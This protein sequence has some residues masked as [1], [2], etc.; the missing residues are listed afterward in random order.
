MGKVITFLKHVVLSDSFGA[1]VDASSLIINVLLFLIALLTFI[2]TFLYNGV[3]L[4][5]LTSHHSMFYGNHFG[6]TIKNKSFH[7]ISISEVFIII[8][9]NNNYYRIK[10]YS[11]KTPIIIEPLSISYIQSDDFT[12]IN[13]ID[14]Y[15]N[16]WSKD[17]ILGIV[18]GEKVLWAKTSKNGLSKRVAKQV[19]DGILTQ[20]VKEKFGTIISVAVNEI[21]NEKVN[22]TLSD[23]VASNET[24]QEDN[25]AVEAEESINEEGIITTDSEK[26][27]YF[28]VRSIASEILDVNRVAMRDRKH[29]CN[30][31]FDDNQ[32]FPIVRLHFNNPDHLRVEFYDEITLTSNGGKKGEKVD[33]EDVS[34]LYTHKE[35]VLNV[36]NQYLD[37]E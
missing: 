21:I 9:Q 27:A 15:H 16:D 32:R 28:I 8:K 37:M 7:S 35:R 26:E 13:N 17:S 11:D 31:L 25:N 36:L 30:I 29:Y 5:E 19:Y 33:I 10:L 22:K 12:Y 6:F 18:Y 24:Q 1:I 4:I 14:W 2:Y 3:S 34:D 20:N 23:A